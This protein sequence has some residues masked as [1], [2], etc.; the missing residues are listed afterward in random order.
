MPYKVLSPIKHGKGAE[1]FF[2]EFGQIVDDNFFT[3]SQVNSLVSVG[4]LEKVREKELEKEETVVVPESIEVPILSD[5]K[6]VTVVEAKEILEKEGD[7]VNLY[8]YLDAEKGQK[9]PRK[10]VVDYIDIRIKD[11]TGGD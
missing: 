7:L 2:L 4:S 8:K 11:L 10:T 5:I 1:V 9:Y 6:K 3:E